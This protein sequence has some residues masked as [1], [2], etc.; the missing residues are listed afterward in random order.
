MMK[1]NLNSYK[2]NLLRKLNSCLSKKKSRRKSIRKLRKKKS[3]Y[4]SKKTL[5]K[6]IQRKI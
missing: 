5:I 6:V 1:L 2:P 4:L 3:K